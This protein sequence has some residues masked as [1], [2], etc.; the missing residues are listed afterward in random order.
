MS[1]IICFWD[2]S[3]LQVSNEIGEKLQNAIM[4]ESIK[5]FKLGAN[6]YAVSGVEKIIT[7]DEAYN[8]FPTETEHLSKLE[9]RLPTSETLIAL[10]NKSLIS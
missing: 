3:K 6:L 9:D 8:V 4:S 7:K 10:E 1:Y 2:K 5:N